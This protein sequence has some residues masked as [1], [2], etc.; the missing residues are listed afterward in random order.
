MR[1][2]PETET[3]TEPRTEI[4]TEILAPL[5]WA[6]QVSQEKGR[7]MAMTCKEKDNHGNRRS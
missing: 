4:G 6:K 5:C 3:G 1:I 7:K 2:E